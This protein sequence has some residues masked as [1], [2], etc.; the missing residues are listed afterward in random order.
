[1]VMFNLEQTDYFS[2]M[3]V[4]LSAISSKGPTCLICVVIYNSITAFCKDLVLIGEDNT[5]IGVLG[6]GGCH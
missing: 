1:M 6:F 2:L 4:K 5:R 3:K